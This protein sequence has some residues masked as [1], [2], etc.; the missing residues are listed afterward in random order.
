[1]LVFGIGYFSL[2]IIFKLTS[3]EQDSFAI[4][5]AV[6]T[7]IGIDLFCVETNTAFVFC[8][9]FIIYL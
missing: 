7:S 8:F 6:I 1:M 5:N 9:K 2:S 4:I 3:D